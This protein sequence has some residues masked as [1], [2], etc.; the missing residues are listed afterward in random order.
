MGVV[1]GGV[2]AMTV[3]EAAEIV[4]RTRQAGDRSPDALRGRLSLEQAYSVQDLVARRLVA[5]G[6]RQTGWKIAGNSP[7]FRELN[8]G[9]TQIRGYLFA[10]SAYPSGHRIDVARLTVSPRLESELCFIMKSALGGPDVTRDQAAAAIEAVAPA[11]EIPCLP[12]PKEGAGGVSIANL[13][14]ALCVAD[15]AYNMGY[16]MGAP[17]EFRAGL[18]D[19]GDVRAEERRNGETTQV[20]RAGDAIDDHLDSLAGLARL[21]HAG[22]LAIEPGQHVMSGNCL[23][24][25]M[26]PGAG[27]VWEASFSSIGRVSVIFD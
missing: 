23:P 19:L 26:A 27:E 22:G 21:L 6:D 20:S 10:S 14:L 2:A 3:D 5:H 17:V 15:N 13:D 1:E 4:W 11:F 24:L 8:H 12:A 16:V 9:A 25:V 7:K 18:L